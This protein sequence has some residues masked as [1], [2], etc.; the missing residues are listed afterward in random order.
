VTLLQN[1]T[2]PYIIPTDDSGPGTD[3]TVLNA[4]FETNQRNAIDNLIHSTANPTLTPAGI[5]DE[6]KTARGNLAN[7][8][9]RMSGVI[10]VDGAIVVPASLVTNTQARSFVGAHN[11]IVNGDFVDW[12]AG[13][14]S[15][16]DGWTLGGAGATIARTGPGE[17][18]TFT[19][20][21]GKYAAR[22]T[23]AGTN[24][25]LNQDVIPAADFAN[26]ANIKGQKI[27]VVV[28]IKTAVASQAFIRIDDGPTSTDSAFHTGAGVEQTL[29]IVHTV[30]ASATLLA[31]KLRIHN[32][33]GDVY[34]GGAILIIS[35]IAPSDW[36][37][38][39]DALLV[40]HT[41]KQ[42]V[43]PAV[44]FK[45]AVGLKAATTVDLIL[46][47][48]A[49]YT[50]KIGTEAS[51]LA[52]TIG[53]IEAN[54]TAVGNIG[55]G[56]DNLMTY[57]LPANLLAVDKAAVLGIAFGRGAANGNTK[58]I[59]FFFGGT[60]V[61][62][63]AANPDNAKG[64]FC[65]FLVIR[66]GAATQK[67]FAAAGVQD[68]QGAFPVYATSAETLSG[69]V[70]IKFTGEATATDDIIQEGWVILGLGA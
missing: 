37:P 58:Q 1:A 27:A 55:T 65:I 14:T 30:S 2:P 22:V 68:N 15:A 18:D 42:R 13:A 52:K 21:A 39:S 24:C 9:A 19:F 49:G 5:I 53:V 6:V 64:W 47:L 40:N 44:D 56:E 57:S 28:K 11:L 66:T 34:F 62:V 45:G 23:R 48:L 3:G 35:D 36:S 25:F 31:L 7:L 50:A 10:D 46:T 70:T 43:T 67:M 63:R 20:G 4:A 33:N 26:Y 16:P 12:T 60:Q 54:F 51:A 61:T 38:Y 41:L 32:S 8:N 29:T 17:A 59:K 69:A